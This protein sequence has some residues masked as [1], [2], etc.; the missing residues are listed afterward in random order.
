[1]TNG[2][3]NLRVN[4][5]TESDEG[6]LILLDFHRTIINYGY[7]PRI[8]RI[9]RLQNERWFHQYQIHKREFDRRLQQDTEQRLYHGCADGEAAVKSIIEHGFNRS[10]AGTQH[11][12]NAFLFIEYTSS[13]AFP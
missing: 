5:P 4:V 12:K 6:Q 9:E 13:S 10:L 2:T 3:Y 7:Q 1:M 8:I 11:G